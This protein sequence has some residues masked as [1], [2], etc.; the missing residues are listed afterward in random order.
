MRKIIVSE[1]VTL[2]GVMED[3]GGSEKTKRGGWAFQFER[4]PEGDKFKLDEVMESEAMLLGRITYEGFAEAWPA[5]E[6][7]FAD[8]M[9]NM[10]KYVVST[11]L[12]KAEW[13]NTKVNN[14]NIVEEMAKIKAQPGGD[15]LVAGSRTLVDTLRQHNLVDEYRLMVYPVILGSGKRLFEDGSNRVALKLTEARPIGDGVLI[16]IY[17]PEKDVKTIQSEPE[18]EREKERR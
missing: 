10:P 7:E 4:G 3:P 13:A 15:V 1:F 14:N 12:K 5:R 2:D 8:K 6:G 18:I 17:H 11:T 9:N 16:L